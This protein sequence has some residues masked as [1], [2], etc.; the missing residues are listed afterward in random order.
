M[1]FCHWL[2]AAFSHDN[3]HADWANIWQEIAC[4]F[5]E[6]LLPK[7]AGKRDYIAAWFDVCYDP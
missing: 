1:I 4:Q 6:E 2:L 3:L 5:G 7:D